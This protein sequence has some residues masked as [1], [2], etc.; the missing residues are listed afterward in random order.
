MNGACEAKSD[1][2]ANAMDAKRDHATT[3][4]PLVWGFKR[5]QAKTEPPLIWGFKSN[6]ANSKSPENVRDFM[7]DEDARL[8]DEN[9]DQEED[10]EDNDAEEDDDQD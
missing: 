7:E 4:P 3:E 1:P 8:R 6:Q 9:D 2:R 5:D 10:E